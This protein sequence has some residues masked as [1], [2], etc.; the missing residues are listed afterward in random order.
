MSEKD[1][2]E[3]LEKRIEKLEAFMKSIVIGEYKDVH[4]HNSPIGAVS[5]GE[6]CSLAFHQGSIG[7]IIQD[8]DDA[9]N[10]IDELDEIEKED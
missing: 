5:V 2:I 4:F 3:Q 8:I 6:G 10:L 7:G 9:E 1:Y